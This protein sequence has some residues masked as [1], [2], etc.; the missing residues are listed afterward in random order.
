MAVAVWVVAGPPALTAQEGVRVAG[1]VT[2]EAT[3]QPIE[4]AIVRLADVAGLV[5]ETLSGPAGGFAFEGVPPGEY[6]IGARRIGYEGLSLALDIGPGGPAPLNLRMTPAAIPLEPLNVDIEGRPPRL[7]ETGFYDRLEEGWGTYFEPAWIRTASAGY[8]RLSRFVENL[9]MRA[10]L[11]RCSQLQV[12]YD[13]RFIGLASG[14]GTSRSRSLNPEGQYRSAAGPPPRLL[15]EL[16]VTDVG[17]AELYTPPAPIPLFAMNDTTLACGVVILWSDWM[18]Q[19]AEIPQITVKLCEPAGRPGEVSLDGFVEDELTEV[20]LPAAHV[21]ASYPASDGTVRRDLAVRTDSL[22]RYRLCD[23]PA[24][25]AVELEAAYGLDA[26]LSQV[27]AAEAGSEVRLAVE[28]TVPGTITGLV[29]NEGTG[30]P[31]R[32]VPVELVG[33]DFRAVSN[34]AGRFSI[35]RLP[36]GAYRIR[37][38]CE[39]FESIAQDVELV[40][41]ASPRV[42]LALRPDGTRTLPPRRCTG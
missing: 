21:F 30:R 29:V 2:E 8:T 40:A 25:V 34:T 18:A 39:G 20:R 38:V 27:V 4:G 35:E 33:T 10:P 37:A 5:R 15:D 3:G 41:G 9:Q 36:P 12:Y 1:T 7:S 28:V 11:S 13:E 6:V 24:G 22:G 31:F 42:M 26:G 19:T 17:A 23:L 16:S 32:N 14:W